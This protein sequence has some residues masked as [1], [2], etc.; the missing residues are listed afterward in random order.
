MLPAETRRREIENKGRVREF[1]FGIQDGLISTVGLLAGM[2]A[3]GS[4]RFTIIMAG[5]ASVIAGAFSMSAGA[6]L[7][8]KAEKEIFE[9]ELRKE[10]GFIEREPYLAQESLLQA[11]SSEGLSREAAYRVVKLLN[12][13][14]PL[15]VATFQEKVLGLG[16]ADVNDPLK[17]A[18]VMA[19]SFILGGVIPVLPYVALPLDIALL[20][21]VVLAGAALFGVGM[22][23]GRLAGQS[24]GRS[25]LEFLVI[26]LMATGIGYAFG[27]LVEYV[28]DIRLPAG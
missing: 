10:E 14:Q 8:S 27:S 28:A 21:A 19:L 22:F 1:V 2:Q 24:L 17:G 4:S 9:H 20:L 23:K 13:Q 18:L 16:S 15:F 5:T 3:G 6:Y 11:L 12:Q 7:S 26:A 25:G